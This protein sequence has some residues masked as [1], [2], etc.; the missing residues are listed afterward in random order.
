MG[1][2]HYQPACALQLLGYQAQSTVDPSSD[3]QCGRLEDTLDVGL[4]PGRAGALD[5]TK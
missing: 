2:P 5:S 1:S 4:Q 3:Y